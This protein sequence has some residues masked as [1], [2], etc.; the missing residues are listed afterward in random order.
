MFGLGH[1]LPVIFLSTLLATARKVASDK[2][3]SAG[4][5]L[6]KIFGLVFLVIGIIV[7]IYALGAW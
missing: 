5:W 1:A 7:I 3:T 2:I 6:T 4:E